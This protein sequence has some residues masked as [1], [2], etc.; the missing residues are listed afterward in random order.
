[1]RDHQ[2]PTILVDGHVHMHDMFDVD[3]F[4][5]CAAVNFSNARH[6][7]G[8]PI[9]GNNLLLLTE[10]S[11]ANFFSRINRGSCKPR[12]WRVRQTSEYTSLLVKGNGSG[13]MVLIA[14]RQVK[15]YE[16]LEVLIIGTNDHIPDNMPINEIL[17]AARECGAIATIIPW[18][19]GKWHLKRRRIL[20]RLL[21][22]DD[23]S[24][25]YLG[26]IGGRLG[27]FPNPKIFV[28]FKKSGIRIIPGSDPLP[29]RREINRVGSFGFSIRGD[30]DIESPAECLK[31]ILSNPDL[32]IQEYGRR[33]SP[34]SF[35]QYQAS[36]QMYKLKKILK[37]ET[38]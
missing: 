6:Q 35:V 18:G 10:S 12:L 17:Y 5:S 13:N 20:L 2:V 4:F 27:W 32:S 24:G 8:M 11:Q 16:G 37:C 28:E 26:D 36:M 14:G 34:I 38:S 9:D 29:F 7:F 15:T 30:I 1:M 33:I 19:F 22:D 3:L 25:I 23:F 21:R 31:I